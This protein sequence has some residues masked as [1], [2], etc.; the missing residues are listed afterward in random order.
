LY[1]NVSNPINKDLKTEDILGN[2][3][4]MNKKEHGIGLI[5][6]KDCVENNNGQLS[7]FCK[8]RYINFQII[9]LMS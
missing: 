8:N 9:F 4:K 6:I 3:S 5:N 7:I 2:T 1:I